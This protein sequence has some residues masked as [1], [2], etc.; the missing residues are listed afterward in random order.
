MDQ[1]STPR[2]RP[3]HERDDTG[4]P[5]E[6]GYP[7]KQPDTDIE[8]DAGDVDETVPDEPPASGRR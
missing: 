7:E 3:G 8:R 2:P 1:E 6:T 4:D 5:L